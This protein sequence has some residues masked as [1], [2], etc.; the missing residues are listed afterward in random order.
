LVF[1]ITLRS[2]IS[3][4][5]TVADQPALFGGLGSLVIALSIHAIA[6]SEWCHARLDQHRFI[7]ASATSIACLT[8]SR[9]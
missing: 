4:L 1:A 6:A 9:A 8:T 2:S 7:H 5:T 3:S